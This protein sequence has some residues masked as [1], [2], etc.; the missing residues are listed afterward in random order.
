MKNPYRNPIINIFGT[1]RWF[2]KLGQC[3]RDGDLPAVEW[4]S[5]EKE[6]WING[7]IYRYDVWEWKSYKMEILECVDL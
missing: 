1:K 2:N 4:Q 3:H 6:W 7:N 5:G